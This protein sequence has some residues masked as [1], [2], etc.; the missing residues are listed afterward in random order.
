M[1]QMKSDK[2]RVI[3]VINEN[4]INSASVSELLSMFK[5]LKNSSALSDKEI[6][7]YNMIDKRLSDINKKRKET[8]EDTDYID[9]RNLSFDISESLM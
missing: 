1:M 3:M 8:E 2:R 5:E 4:T 7:Y 6:F 9:M